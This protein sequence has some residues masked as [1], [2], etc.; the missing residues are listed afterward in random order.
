MPFTARAR[1]L[2][3]AVVW[4]LVLFGTI[5]IIQNRLSDAGSS[6]E[7]KIAG[8]Q[9]IEVKDTGDIEEVTQKVYFDIEIAGKPAG[10][11]FQ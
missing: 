3:T 8:L 11:S 1:L 6:S 9:E 10:I 7:R 2:S 5:A 4:I